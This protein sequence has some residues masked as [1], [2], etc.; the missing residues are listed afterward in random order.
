MPTLLA[1]SRI[2]LMYSHTG[3]FLNCFFYP[4][5]MYIMSQSLLSYLRIDSLS[6]SAPTVDSLT[7]SAENNAA[8]YLI[9]MSLPDCNSEN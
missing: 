7:V 1:G 6:P 4:S 3:L 9:I 5:N 8:M 2:F